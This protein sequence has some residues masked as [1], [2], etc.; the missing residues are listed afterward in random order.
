MIKFGEDNL[1]E[2]ATSCTPKN[3]GGKYPMWIIV[4]YTQGEHLPPHAHLYKPDQRPSKSSLITKFI[5][6]KNAPKKLADIKTM[7]GKPPVPKEYADLIIL[8]AKDKRK[9]GTNNWIALLD[10]W[11]GLEDTLTW[12]KG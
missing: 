12:N 9:S 6:S 10:D 8:W 3:Y 7:K 11:Q 2:M 4:Q 5:I 1:H